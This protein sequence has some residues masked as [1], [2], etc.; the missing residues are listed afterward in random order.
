MIVTIG[1][2]TYNSAADL[3]SCLAALRAQTYTPIH[4]RIVDN[5]SSDGTRVWLAA[6]APDIELIANTE[7]VGFGRAHNQL[8]RDVPPDGAYL[9]LNPDV[10]LA[11]DYLARLVAAL[12][13]GNLDSGVGSAVGKL[14]SKTDD[15]TRTNLIYSAGHAIT[16]T[17]YTFNIGHGMADA[18][19]F[20][21]AR[22]VFGAS[23]AAALYSGRMVAQTGGFDPDI[24]LY[25]EDTDLDWRARRR[26]WACFYV[27]AAVAYH[28]GSSSNT[29]YN[30]FVIGNR[31]LSAIKNADPLTLW[32]GVLPM[33]L[34]HLAARLLLTPRFGLKLIAHIVPRLRLYG[35]KRRAEGTAR[36]VT[37]REQ[38]TWHNWSARQP[39]AKRWR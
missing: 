25:A 11:P 7:N 10:E 26:G 12:N 17:G 28:R 36:R 35:R 9:C 19:A 15:G 18:P 30:H 16:R 29:P 5:A 32:T 38:W 2:V 39:G 31:Y 20:N 22:A 33:L 24:F 1:I 8:I 14:L 21:Q 37:L 27:P 34:A 6:H 3:P 4:L 23:G 13:D